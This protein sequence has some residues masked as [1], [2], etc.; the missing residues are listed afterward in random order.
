MPTG[1]P[2]TTLAYQE[3]LA[4]LAARQ[5]AARCRVLTLATQARLADQRAAVAVAER[6]NFRV[7]EQTAHAEASRFAQL[8]FE[9]S[10]YVLA[11][12]VQCGQQH[13][14]QGP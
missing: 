1:N 10:A 13:R 8:I 5:S 2:S 14:S 3:V 7:L 12:P 6:D 11:A 9:L 4:D